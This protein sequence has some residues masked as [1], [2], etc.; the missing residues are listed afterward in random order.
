MSNLLNNKKKK[1]LDR[2][3]K[4]TPAQEFTLNNVETNEINVSSVEPEPLRV[5]EKP[6]KTKQS[7]TTVRVEKLT[8]SKLNALVQMGKAETVDILVDILIDE[9]V[10]HQLLKDEKKTYDI[11]LNVLRKKEEL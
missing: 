11:L 10:S 7:T 5:E 8:R 3:P 4:I 1:L 9:Y 6:K 2:G